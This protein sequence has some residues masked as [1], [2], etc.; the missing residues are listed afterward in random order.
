MDA[1]ETFIKTFYAVVEM[2]RQGL[3]MPTA[4]CEMM[5]DFVSDWVD[6]F[7]EESCR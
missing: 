1:E 5:E 4:K 7:G 6:A 2:M 3:P